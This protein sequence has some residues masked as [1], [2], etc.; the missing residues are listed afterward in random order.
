MFS[1]AKGEI[2]FVVFHFTC[3]QVQI[4]AQDVEKTDNNLQTEK[5]ARKKEVDR[6]KACPV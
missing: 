3:G 6:N 1:P 5:K 2:N 4:Q